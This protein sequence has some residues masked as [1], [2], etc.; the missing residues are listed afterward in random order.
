MASDLEI[1]M[2]IK[3]RNQARRAMRQAEK[4]LERMGFTADKTRQ[5]FGRNDREGLRGSVSVLRSKLLL[6]AFAMTAVTATFGA[7][8][9]GAR[10]LAMASSA[11]TEAQN[12]VNEV[13]GGPGARRI[14]E[15]AEDA[16]DR[17]GQTRVEA[18]QAIGT[19]G[20]LFTSLEI[21]RKPAE[22]MSLKLV[23]LAADLASFNDV[24]PTVALDKLQSG[25]VGEVRPLRQFGVALNETLVEAKAFELGFEQLN[26]E[27]TEGE[28]VLARYE[29]I[30]EKTTNS[31]GDFERTSGDLANANRRMK[32]LWSELAV[33]AGSKL[34]PA[35]KDVTESLIGW[36]QSDAVKYAEDLG[37]ALA[38]VVPVAAEVV[39]AINELVAMAYDPIVFTIQFARDTLKNIPLPGTDYNLQDL[40]AAATIGAPMLLAGREDDFAQMMHPEWYVQGGKRAPEGFTIERVNTGPTDAQY[41]E[42]FNRRIR[43]ENPEYAAYAELETARIKGAQIQSGEGGKLSVLSAD[44]AEELSKAY[45]RFRDQLQGAISVSTAKA[46]NKA[47]DKAQEEEARRLTGAAGLLDRMAGKPGPTRF[48]PQ[49]MALISGYV[50]D[51]Q[52]AL[53]AT[54]F[55]EQTAGIEAVAAEIDRALARL[56][57]R[58][59]ELDA[60]GREETVTFKALEEQMDALHDAAARVNFLD[61]LQL[62]PQ[63]ILA[64]ALKDELEA[65]EDQIRDL[66]EAAERSARAAMDSLD[67]F[68]NFVVDSL[69]RKYEEAHVLR[70][71]QLADEEKAT[72]DTLRAEMEAR[73]ASIDAQMAALDALDRQVT[74]EDFTRR[75]G[76]AY[77]KRD[78][79]RIEQ[80]FARFQRD[81]Q[82]QA[83]GTQLAAIRE[84]H[85]KELDA[86]R[87]RYDR[88]REIADAA[89][90]AATD[91]YALG[92]EARKLLESGHMDELIELIQS[93]YDRW[94]QEGLSLGQQLI[95]GLRDSGVEDEILRILG[96]VG[97]LRGGIG[98]PGIMTPVD[99]T[100]SSIGA[101]GLAEAQV[102]HQVIVDL[103]GAIFTGTATENANEINRIVKETL[104][105]EFGSGAVV[106]GVRS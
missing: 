22:D 32:A 91:S 62:E 101:P 54:S 102:A 67:Q 28:K 85:R 14:I 100:G 87:E 44:D 92:L 73:T 57:I 6:V 38:A 3:A 29:L 52:K 105:R 43:E 34:E 99:P 42:D 36:L 106:A 21:G 88:E 104:E 70:M 26:G 95:F 56:G 51:A 5:R 45:T 66:S 90:Q 16:A 33:I 84:Q 72:L 60:E 13:Y 41:W 98:T 39:K 59:A 64:E 94:A 27:F 77:D 55:E 2:S 65:L 86:V 23:Q 46:L 69:Q 93:N 10:K 1:Q 58:M 48:S 15:W 37:E 82:R 4:D 103:R 31:Q 71:Q 40:L 68:A 96:L 8:A 25:L 47:W 24:D 35:M 50:A 11:L 18:T 19:F 80:D 49:N 79:F 53:S 89:Y 20:N 75:I 17:L 9:L 78:R 97:A 7:A 12:K 30:M 74:T 63:R 83:L 76:L 81:E 61:T